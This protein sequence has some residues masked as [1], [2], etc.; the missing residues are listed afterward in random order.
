M[1]LLAMVAAYFTYDMQEKSN[2]RTDHTNF[3]KDISDLQAITYNLV[4]TY[5]AKCTKDVEQ[6][7]EI[8]ELWKSVPRSGN[9]IIK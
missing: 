1:I 4:Q 7:K 5:N 9:K 3:N 6:D 8:L 2:N